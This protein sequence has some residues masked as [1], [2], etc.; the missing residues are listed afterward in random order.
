MSRDPLMLKVA[1]P[2]VRYVSGFAAVL[3]SDGY[4][5]D[6]VC[7]HVELLAHVSRWL[8]ARRL[9]LIDFTSMHVDE[10]LHARSSE[11]YAR[12]LTPRGIAPLLA[13]L[14]ES[15]AIPG[16]LVMLHSASDDLLASFREY[17]TQEQGLV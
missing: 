6:S 8:V 13:H 16:D 4:L 5:R 17:L 10:S 14:R 7:H 1:G 11:G 9:D 12:L 3:E 15:G 2:L